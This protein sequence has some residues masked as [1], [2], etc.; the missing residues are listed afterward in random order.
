M[1]CRNLGC[2][3]C[4]VG[5]ANVHVGK[6][7]TFQVVMA[8]TCKVASDLRPDAFKRFLLDKEVL[9]RFMNKLDCRTVGLGRFS[10]SSRRIKYKSI[11]N[12][13]CDLARI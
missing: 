12:I 3:L 6:A 13:I 2:L 11:N 9:Y 1:H 4:K 10:K 7:A 5:V 8:T